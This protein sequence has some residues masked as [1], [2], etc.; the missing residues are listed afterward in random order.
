MAF[1]TSQLGRFGEY[2]QSWHADAD[3]DRRAAHIAERPG[4]AATMRFAA[5]LD[6]KRLW[7]PS[8][9]TWLAWKRRFD[10]LVAGSA[11]LLPV[12]CSRPHPRY[13]S[14]CWHELLPPLEHG[15]LR[16]FAERLR[17]GRVADNISVENATPFVHRDADAWNFVIT[18]AGEIL[19][20]TEHYEAVKHPCISGGDQV[21]SAGR[22]GVDRRKIR[23]VDLQSGH[24][25]RSAVLRGTSAATVLMNTTDRIFREYVAALLNPDPLDPSFICVW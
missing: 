9:P 1:R 2:I 18:K 17:A 23:M 5:L 13:P 8:D 16:W 10:S 6:S 24:F 21:W 3:P 22:L 4:G 20:S 19:V 12:R 7:D 25:V 15:N 14:E 11:V